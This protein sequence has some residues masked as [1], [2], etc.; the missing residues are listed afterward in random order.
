MAEYQGIIEEI[1]DIEL[2]MFQRVRSSG[3]APCQDE[4]DAFRKIRASIYEMWTGEMLE[5]YLSDLKA[6]QKD[7]RNLL[8]EKY[9]R[10]DNLMP[11]LNTNP[12]IDK[13]VEIETGW[14][15]EIR[16]RYPT[17]YNRVCRS[18]APAQDGS[19]F[20]IYLQ[21]E[22]ETYGDNTLELYYK[23]LINA[24]DKGENLSLKMLERLVR[25]G[26]Y[27]DLDHAEK[28]L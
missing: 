24:L 14:Q 26:G 27:N 9:A 7:G 28:S 25:K 13:I 15:E 3:T 5:S 10:M 17:I 6:A 8:M 16:D 11:L 23:N 1:L 2:Y 4:P 12:L 19:N 20:S 21:C 22:L 18:T